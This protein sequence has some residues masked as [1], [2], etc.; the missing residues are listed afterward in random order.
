MPSLSIEQMALK[1]KLSRTRGDK[2]EK[3]D[4]TVALSDSSRF[5]FSFYLGNGLHNG[6]ILQNNSKTQND[7]S[8]SLTLP[9]Q[10]AKWIAKSGSEVI[11]IAAEDFA[12]NKLGH[13]LIV[14]GEMSGGAYVYVEGVGWIWARLCILA[15]HLWDNEFLLKRMIRKNKGECIDLFGNVPLLVQIKLGIQNRMEKS[16]RLGIQNRSL[17]SVALEGVRETITSKAVE[18]VKVDEVKRQDQVSTDPRPKRTS[19]EVSSEGEARALKSLA[20]GKSVDVESYKP[21]SPYFAAIKES[22]APAS[23]PAYSG[24]REEY[25]ASLEPRAAKVVDEL[26]SASEKAEMSMGRPGGILLRACER[27]LGCEV[28]APT[29]EHS[30]C[31]SESSPVG[32]KTESGLREKPSKKASYSERISVD[33]VFFHNLVS[34]TV[35]SKMGDDANNY[36]PVGDWSSTTAT[37]APSP[38][39]T[40]VRIFASGNLS[41]LFETN[42]ERLQ[43]YGLS[44]TYSPLFPSDPVFSRVISPPPTSKFSTK[45]VAELSSSDLRATAADFYPSYYSLRREELPSPLEVFGYD[46]DS[47]AN[48]GSKIGE[49]EGARA[50]DSPRVLNPN[51]VGSTSAPGLGSAGNE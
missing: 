49:V 16:V 28:V 41:S 26:F 40:L 18:P 34:E 21:M 22:R 46:L 6:D 20:P 30:I 23:P 10:L 39:P 32:P 14:D 48:G 24:W 36:R 43:D 29:G 33:P 35:G 27:L 3:G 47:T 9:F 8:P 13:G 45:S 25:Q 44:R 1:E 2:A 37:L 5:H 19:G 42:W 12:S 51:V 15:S 31:A 17:S 4:S 50:R 11:R 38:S 7:K